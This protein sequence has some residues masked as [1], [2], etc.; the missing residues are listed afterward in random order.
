MCEPIRYLYKTE[1]KLMKTLITL[2][3]LML[4]PFCYSQGDPA[5]EALRQLAHIIDNNPGQL[6]RV[7]AALNNILSGAQIKCPNAVPYTGEVPQLPPLSS[8]A[9]TDVESPLCVHYQNFIDQGV[10]AEALKRALKYREQNIAQFENNNFIGIADY[11]QDSNQERFYSL[12]LETGEVKKS[13]V[14]HSEGPD[15][16]RTPELM[17]NKCSDRTGDQTGYTRPG[18]FRVSEAYSAEHANLALPIELGSNQNQ[19]IRLD[20][21][22]R[23]IN[24]G[25]RDRG[26][27]MGAATY[28]GITNGPLGRAFGAFM[29]SRPTSEESEVLPDLIG[30][31]LLYSHVGDI[32]QDF[33][34]RIDDEIPG[35]ENQ[36]Q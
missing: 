8:P 9:A 26:I 16:G 35:W 4:S 5:A 11:T 6:D 12:N 14:T 27:V 28:A 15:S 3:S 18:F 34:D 31:G 2:F 1:I 33:T 23:G 21:L 7:N 29:V 17:L 20:G 36:C 32:C 30:G 25:A 10:P 24:D 19:R 13:K 22:N